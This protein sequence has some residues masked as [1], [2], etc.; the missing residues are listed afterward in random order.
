MYGRPRWADGNRDPTT[1]SLRTRV[2][3]VGADSARLTQTPRIRRHAQLG[4]P[5]PGR[6][7][8][9]R[10]REPPT[11]MVSTLLRR[12]SRDPTQTSRVPESHALRSQAWGMKPPMCS[13]VNPTH[14]VATAPR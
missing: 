2:A 8:Q 12:V 1:R 7:R 3:D 10:A 6:R 13:L 5:R 9:A 14:L 11:P 4:M